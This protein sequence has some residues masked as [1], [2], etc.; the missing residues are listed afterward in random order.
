MVVV[1]EL[2]LG[3]GIVVVVGVFEW[4]SGGRGDWAGWG[5]KSAALLLLLWGGPHGGLEVAAGAERGGGEERRGAQ[6]QPGPEE[7]QRAQASGGTED[8]W[9]AGAAR[10]ATA[11]A[12]G[13]SGGG[14][15]RALGETTWLGRGGD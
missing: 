14:S 11:G 4:P 5:R 12:N 1:V 10:D 8:S 9:G 3:R 13:D 2:L 7:V 6:A 15:G